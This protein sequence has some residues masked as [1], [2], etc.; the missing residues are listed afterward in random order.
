MD[1]GV[2]SRSS[3]ACLGMA[4]V[5]YCELGSDR[6]A[7]R[8]AAAQELEKA[9]DVVLPALEQ[10]LATASSLEVQRRLEVLARKL[11]TLTGE[12]LRTL[13]AIEALERMQS[14]NASKLL[15]NLA[16]G[17]PASRLT[18]EARLSLDRRKDKE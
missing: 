3:A 17:A 15:Q 11:R 12:G 10:A 8:L 16:T 13:R 5:L 7:E 6:F 14:P 2:N 9:G 18:K 4:L 1:V